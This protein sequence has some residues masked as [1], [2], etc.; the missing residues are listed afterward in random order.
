MG[1]YIGFS[2]PLDSD[3]VEQTAP[4]PKDTTSQRSYKST[5]DYFYNSRKSAFGNQGYRALRAFAT[6]PLRRSINT[7]SYASQMLIAY[8]QPVQYFPPGNVTQLKTPENKSN[9]F[10][11]V[12]KQLPSV[13]RP[14][15]LQSIP[16]RMPWL[17]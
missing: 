5:S 10:S 16:T 14:T 11:W 15:P 17:K 13:K 9:I 2:K 4:F 3:L 8:T 6:T 7:P 1:F 12:N